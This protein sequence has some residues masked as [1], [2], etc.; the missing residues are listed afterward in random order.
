[1][2][3]HFHRLE[4]GPL[5]LLLLTVNLGESFGRSDDGPRNGAKGRC[6]SRSRPAD[7]SKPI[8]E[9][10]RFTFPEAALSLTHSPTPTA[11]PISHTSR[12]NTMDVEVFA[13]GQSKARQERKPS[14]TAMTERSDFAL[15][16]GGSISRQ[17]RRF[18]RQ[19]NQRRRREYYL[20]GPTMA[21]PFDD[22]QSAADGTYRFDHVPLNQPGRF[23]FLGGGNYANNW[24]DYELTASKPDQE[25]NLTLKGPS[26][27]AESIAGTI[28]NAKRRTQSPTAAVYYYAHSTNA[29]RLWA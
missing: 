1:L 11:T 25:F 9:R 5:R 3:A 27:P 17:A 24:Q 18:I 12:P 14:L 6:I 8:A 2:R 29:D 13:P 19:T 4:F 21:W 26:R 15:S 23:L 7:D 28:T 22:V 10:K 16:P 20:S